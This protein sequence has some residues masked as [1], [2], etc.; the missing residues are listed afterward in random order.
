MKAIVCTKYG[1]VDG[2]Q[3][4]EVEKP[5]P[6][7][8][9]VL[10]KVYATTVAAGDVVVRRL[11][12]FKYLAIWPFA[13]IVFGIKNLRKKILGHEFAGKVEAVGKDVTLFNKGDHI[14]G[15]TTGYGSGAHAEYVCLPEDGV[16][17][18]KPA[19]TTCEEAAAVPVGGM[20][21]LYILKR[22]NIQSGQKV[23]VYGASG[24]VGT[25]AVQLAR[26][27]G[28]EVTGV[29]SSKNVELV[30]SLGAEK[31]VDY[32]KEDFTQSVEKYDVIFDAVGKISSSHCRKVLKKNGFYLTVKCTKKEK[33]ENL[34]FLKE[35]VETGTIK[36]VI[37]KRYTLEQIVEAH[38]YVEKGHKKGNVVIT[39]A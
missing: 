3:L 20:A 1:S 8:N 2:L 26:F 27:Y 12:F 32:T 24:S 38:E 9:E 21:A 33:T 4:R 28:A 22:A 19:N 30:K 35:L 16:L 15:T 18:K 23:L 14:F 37:D 13:R 7:N 36:V 10:V 31:V 29:C 11:T 39:V 25:Y 17:A 34:L 6:R 5:V